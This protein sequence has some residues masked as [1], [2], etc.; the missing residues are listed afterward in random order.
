MPPPPSSTRR[1][2]AVV[3]MVPVLV[4]FAL[5]A[6]AWPAARTA[7]RDLPVG[8]AGPAEAAA[9]VQQQLE[10]HGD[11]FD[12]HR[13]ADE[14]AARRAIVHR[15]VYGAVVT[16]PRGPRL[17]TASAASPAVA[18]LLRDA[19]ASQ[20]PPNAPPQVEDVV[21]A[22]ASD[23]RGS[24]LSASVLPLA[25]AAVATGLLVAMGRLGARRSVAALFAASALI[26]AV[27]AAM[28]SSWLEILPGNWWAVAGSVSLTVLAG[29]ALVAGCA[30]LLGHPG[31]GLG[32]VLVVLLGNPFS[33]V[34]SAPEL[35]PRPAGLIGQL[36]PPGAGGSLLRSVSFFDGNAALGPS[37]VLTAWSVLGLAAIVL[38]ALR[39]HARRAAATP[40]PTPTTRTPPT[41]ATQVA[42]AD[43]QTPTAPGNPHTQ[44]VG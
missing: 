13:F 27:S 12:V 8:V 40:A 30:A 35:L 7:P 38:G 32:A 25:L 21:P 43:Q 19:V 42:T 11:A 10:Q 34:P 29:A 4:A 28:T 15:D 14:A 23:P 26:G 5:W 41:R 20:T 31:L 1:A 9:P 33:G 22:P 39:P 24:A 18:Q 6:F 36:L 16:T 44:P 37:L 2:V 3:V 17:L